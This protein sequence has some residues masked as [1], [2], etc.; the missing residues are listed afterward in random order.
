M[1]NTFPWSSKYQ[2]SIFQKSS[3]DT[4][5]KECIWTSSKSSPGKYWW[6]L[7]FQAGN[8]ES[9]ILISNLKMS[10]SSSLISK[11]TKFIN[12]VILIK[13]KVLSNSYSRSTNSPRT[14]PTSSSQISNPMTNSKTGLLQIRGRVSNLKQSRDNSFS[15]NSYNTSTNSN[16]NSNNH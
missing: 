2:E 12:R 4:I 9:Y 8:A 6:V 5:I 3:N 14:S 7:T 1:V 15:T 10:Y 13:T 11:Y 16:S